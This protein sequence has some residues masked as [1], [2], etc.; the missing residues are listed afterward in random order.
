MSQQPDSF[1]FAGYLGVLRRRWLVVL[2]LVLVGVLAAGV[3]IA[4]SP[5][6]YTSTA[7][8]NVTATGVAQSQGGAVAG[9]RTNSAVNLDTEAQIVKSSSV[10]AIAARSLHSPLTSTA[11]LGNVSVAVPANSSI[12][13]IS[14][15]AKS[16][17]QAAAC[18]NAFAAAYIQNRNSTAADTID[19][20]LKTVRGELT[21]LEKSTTRLSLQVSTFP[22]N[23]PQRASAQ[24]QLQSDSSQLKSLANQAA[25]LSAQAAASS[26]GTI[27]SKAIP[28]K[29]PTSPKKKIILPS[30]LLV[31]L[32]L[33][34]I[35]AFAWDKR[36]TTIKDAKNL[37]QP[38]APVL[39]AVSAKDLGGEPL[40][41]PRSPAWLDFS[42]LAR[43]TTV[44]LGEDRPLLLVAGVSAGQGTSIAAANLAVALA[45]TYS[46]VILVCPSGQGT[47]QL[48]G[49]PDSRIL[50]TRAA[51]ELATGEL[52][53]EEVALQ[54]AGFPGLRVV[55]LA[56]NLQD[57]SHAQARV[58]AEQLRI[59]A[60]F[61]VV[62]APGESTGPDALALAEYCSGALLTVEISVTR[63]PEIEGSVRRINR[64]GT[65]VLGLVA[66]PRL[67]LPARA[68][69]STGRQSSGRQSTRRQSIGRQF[70][71]SIRLRKGPS[72]ATPKSA[73]QAPADDGED[74]SAAPVVHADV[75]DRHNGT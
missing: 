56:E 26:G 23:S 29:S 28:L 74:H 35:V 41:P 11:L 31:G 17:V 10:A 48:L 25:S 2:V 60:D 55:V 12:L 8:V 69:K 49:L 52:S 58:L 37:G 18:A 1:E 68:G 27:I 19:A 32:L 16:P 20:E 73:T 75:A 44:A 72:G 22:V 30:G 34:L 59:S 39:L 66:V 54:P 47:T 13:Q 51:A 45:R 40:A 7:T 24:S 61:T 71:G 14:C 50:D 9:G 15:Q 33:G 43:S 57:L 5:K 64:L 63:R 42:E 38:G 21:T 36:D 4:G 65:T 62:E 67:R 3:Y 70:T 46:A 53:V 6:A